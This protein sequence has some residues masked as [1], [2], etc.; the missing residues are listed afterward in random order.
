MDIYYDNWNMQD[1]IFITN[2]CIMY[3]KTSLNLVNAMHVP[4]MAVQH[5]PSLILTYVARPVLCVNDLDTVRRTW[6][7]VH[8]SHPK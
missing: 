4:L 3:T 2:R 6:Y 8:M 7:C 5:I 1:C